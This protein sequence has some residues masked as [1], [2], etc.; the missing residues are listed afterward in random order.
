MGKGRTILLVAGMVLV[1]CDVHLAMSSSVITHD[2]D[3]GI[4]REEKQG[5]KTKK[6]LKD[7]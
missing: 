5:A 2:G 6:Q 3:C 7:K 4:Q 1:V